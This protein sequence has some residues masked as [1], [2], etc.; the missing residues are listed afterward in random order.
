MWPHPLSCLWAGREK[1]S[2]FGLGWTPLPWPLQPLQGCSA[3]QSCHLLRS[4]TSSPAGKTSLRPTWGLFHQNKNWTSALENLGK[5]LLTFSLV[6]PQSVGITHPGLETRE[7]HAPRW[8]RGTRGE[9]RYFLDVLKAA[10]RA[11]GFLLSN[12]QV[13]PKV[14]KLRDDRHASLLNV[15]APILHPALL[16]V[17]KPRAKVF[18]APWDMSLCPKTGWLSYPSFMLEM[19]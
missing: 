14:P 16:C 1:H 7:I 4:E 11:E 13:N 10:Q 15:L 19:N 2:G 8:V 17:T 5:S 12:I 3:S 9:A 6:W 18:L